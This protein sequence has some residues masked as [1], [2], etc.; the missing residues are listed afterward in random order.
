MRT[1]AP[2]DFESVVVA[3]LERLACWMRTFD[4]LAI[5]K[6]GVTALPEKRWHNAKYGYASDKMWLCM[7]VLHATDPETCRQL[8]AALI[9]STIK[10]QGCQNV[11]PGGEGIRAGSLHHCHVYLVCAPAGLGT[12]LAYWCDVRREATKSKR[13]I[14]CGGSLPGP[15]S[16]WTG[17]LPRPGLSLDRVSPWTVASGLS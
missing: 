14:L 1:T 4:D 5:F 8:E 12:S 17:S 11:A 2:L 3:C 10:V 16:P 7:D 6:F 15:V 13:G 9:A